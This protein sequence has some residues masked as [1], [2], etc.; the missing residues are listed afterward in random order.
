MSTLNNSSNDVKTRVVDLHLASLDGRES[1][2]MSNV[3]VIES[4]PFITTC[5]IPGSYAH[6]KGLNLVDSGQK[7]DLLLGQDNAEALMPLE[8]RKGKPGEPFA[9]KTLFGWSVNGQ[10]KFVEP[11]NK[12]VISN[13]ISSSL[14]VDV[15]RLW[16]IENEGIAKDSK[17]WSVE[18]KQVADLWDKSVRLVDGHY[19]LPIPWK[20]NASV[21]NNVGVAFSRLKSLRSNLDKRGLF[22]KYDDEIIKLVRNDYAEVVPDNEINA[23]GKVW[24]LPHQAV[25]TDKK[26]D[27][28]RVVFDCA[29]KY[30]GESLNMKCLQGLDLNNKLLS[31]L[32][33]FR[34][35]QYAFTGDV[36]AM[37]NQV[38]IPIYDRNALRFLWD[39]DGILRH[40]RMTSHLFGGIWCASSATY[41]LRRTLHDF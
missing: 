26:P 25:V 7:V 38:K 11:T 4:I 9:C 30:Q 14:A 22:S 32:L 13:F 23:E 20:Q 12:V 6:F 10:N 16:Q 41:A 34:E 8:V 21:P 19:E 15:E 1:L 31:V 37:Y 33:R 18:D 29:S 24:Y 28:L 36:E 27:K 5:P 2:K 39:G 35:H 40:F 17:A 3:Y